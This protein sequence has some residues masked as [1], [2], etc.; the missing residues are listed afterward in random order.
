MP[1]TGVSYY[2]YPYFPEE[3][4]FPSSSG[5][6]IVGTSAT[7]SLLWRGAFSDCYFSAAFRKAVLITA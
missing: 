1:L 4:Y 3:K 2:A 5:K 6:S 7:I